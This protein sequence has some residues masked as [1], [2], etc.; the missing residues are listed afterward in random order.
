M[1][2]SL[3]TDILKFYSSSVFYGELVVILFFVLVILWFKYFRNSGFV[4]FFEFI[5]ETVYEFF[6]DILWKEEDRWIKVYV[7]SV[8]FIIL[9]SNFLWVIVEIIS[10]IWGSKIREFTH[11][12]EHNILQVPTTDINFNIAMALV[13]VFLVI[14][15][16]FKSLWI[17]KGIYEYF[18]IFWKNYVPYEFGK[19]SKWIDIPLFLVVKVLDI[20]ISVFLWLLEIVWHIAKIIS[21][22]F[23]L[24]WNMT[25]GWLLLAMLVVWLAGLTSNLIW[26]DFP[27]IWPIVI[28]FQW[29]LVALI[30][31]LV[32]PLLIAI[33]MKVAKS[34]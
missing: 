27:I 28:H 1:D 17:P 32:F 14:F 25:S 3:F 21:L 13:W 15:V 20:I 31:A 30:Q 12:F 11:F 8:F 16:Q 10:P 9:T 5:F 4:L 18:P 26:I 23:R 19:K 33:F 6:E 24:F 2:N 34:H 22:A 7:T 29:M